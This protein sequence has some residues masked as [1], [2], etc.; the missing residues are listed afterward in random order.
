MQQ[1]PF[2]PVGYG[3]KEKPALRRLVCTLSLSCVAFLCGCGG[4]R[5][6]PGMTH[7]A[8]PPPT[9]SISGTVTYKGAL[10]PEPRLRCG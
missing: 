7:P 2:A 10:F 3:Q 4:S 1:S 6:D 9:D 8:D 5:N